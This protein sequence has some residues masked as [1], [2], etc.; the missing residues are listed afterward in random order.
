MKAYLEERLKARWYAYFTLL[1][2]HFIRVVWLHQYYGITY[3]MA[4]YKVNRVML[5]LSPKDDPD[6]FKDSNVL[7]TE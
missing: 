4:I 1:A 2:L 6:E 5:F 3:I 7:P